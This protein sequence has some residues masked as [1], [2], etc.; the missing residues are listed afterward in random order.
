MF[1]HAMLLVELAISPRGANKYFFSL[2]N[3]GKSEHTQGR[4]RD[5]PWD[6][7]YHIS[8]ITLRTR[9]S[10]RILTYREPGAEKIW[11]HRHSEYDE[12]YNLVMKRRE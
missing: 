5:A 4:I 8:W 2:G 3:D 11:D 10:V 12:Y 9:S 6:R 7:D 1:K